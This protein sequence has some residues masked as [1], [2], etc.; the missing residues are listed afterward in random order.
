[1]DKKGSISER[2]NDLIETLYSG[3]KSSFAR[4]VGMGE[5]SVR[6]YLAGT[7]PKADV[8]GKMADALAVSCEWLI[9]GSGPMLKTD[10][11]APMGD[12]DLTRAD[13]Y[14]EQLEE[15]HARHKNEMEECRARIEQLIAQK[16]RL[17][18][19][20]ARNERLSFQHGATV[21]PIVPDAPPPMREL[22]DKPAPAPERL[23][24]PR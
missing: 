21:K 19:R 10:A 15:C 1:M 3:N 7:V 22:P 8:I 18:E 16:T 24:D 23:E 17:E 12:H 4:A 20:L 5:S 9:L 14:K 6:S 11:T 13:V 2:I